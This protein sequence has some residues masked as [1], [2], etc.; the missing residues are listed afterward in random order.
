M[1]TYEGVPP[2]GRE[3]AKIACNNPQAV[4]D[5][6]LVSPDGRL[7][8]W[9]TRTHETA[10]SA[11]AILLDLLGDEKRAMTLHRRFMYRSLVDRLKSDQP[12]TLT[13]DEIRRTIEAIEEVAETTES[14][15]AAVDVQ[16]A[17]MLIETGIGPGGVPIK[18]DDAK[19][20]TIRPNPPLKT[21]EHK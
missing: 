11:L 2:E 6:F 5:D 8:S 10:A 21:E 12:F 17:P 7:F 15:R 3:P 20:N 14:E 4:T 13:E 18:W 1:K 9:G 16:P 19:P